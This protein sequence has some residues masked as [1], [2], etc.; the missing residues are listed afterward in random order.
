[1]LRLNFVLQDL[2]GLW[3]LNWCRCSSIFNFFQ[4]FISLN[5]FFDVHC[6]FTYDLSG[7]SSICFN[8]VKIII[9]TI[10][11]C[12]LGKLNSFFPI[13]RWFWQIKCNTIHFWYVIFFKPWNTSMT[14]FLFQR[15]ILYSIF[16]WN[17]EKIFVAT[18]S[19]RP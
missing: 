12:F 14:V 16:F 17:I 7:N 4:D 9:Q 19:N 15:W 2:C 8:I 5:L 18:K 6:F 1:M 3:S 13:F 10:I 11:Q